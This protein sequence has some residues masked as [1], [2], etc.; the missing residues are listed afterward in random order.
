MKKADNQYD[1]GTVLRLKRK[2]PYDKMSML[3]IVSRARKGKSLILWAAL[4]IKGRIEVSPLVSINK[5]LQASEKTSLYSV[6]SMDAICRGKAFD[7]SAYP[8]CARRYLCRYYSLP[9]RYVESPGVVPFYP[10][11]EQLSCFEE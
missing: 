7:E 3:K 10:E 5:L 8:P 9:Q 6:L 1:I 11:K 4:L 2:S